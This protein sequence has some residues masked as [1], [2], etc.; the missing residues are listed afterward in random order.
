MVCPEGAISRDHPLFIDRNRCKLCFNCVAVCPSKA[1]H[2]AGVEMSVE[3]IVGKVV[4]YKAFFDRSGGGV[5]LS[6]GE[7]TLPVEFTSTLLKQLKVEG[8]HTLLETSGMF[9]L[10]TFESLLL[11][12][13][14]TIYY[15]IKLI[16]PYDHERYC[17][18]S[19]EIILDNF[20]R[21]HEKSALGSVELLPRTPL[22]P[23]ITDSERN[24]GQLSEFY[25]KHQVEKAVLLANN[26]VWIQKLGRLGREESFDTKDPIRTFYDDKKKKKIKDYFFNQG[27]EIIFG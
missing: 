1:L 23:G 24:I 8:I 7:P 2:P 17:G 11:P 26:P 15:D 27:I 22:I 18:V 10:A 5:T 21:L 20:I 3:E 16:D 14:D 9:N 25:S 6:G 19:N 12:F 4:K 13:I